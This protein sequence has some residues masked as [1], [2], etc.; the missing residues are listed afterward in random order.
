MGLSGLTFHVPFVLALPELFA[1]RA[2]LER[3]PQSPG[4]KLQTRFGPEAANGVKIHNTLEAVLADTDIELIIVGTPS[5]THYSIAKSCLEAGKHGVLRYLLGVL[6][7]KLTC[8][9]DTPPQ[10]YWWISL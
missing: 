1:L 6:S 9:L 4:G 8:Y 3:N 10:K 7:D 5:E 2:V